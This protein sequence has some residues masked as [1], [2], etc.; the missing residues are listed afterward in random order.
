M[1]PVFSGLTFESK[2]LAGAVMILTFIW[3]CNELSPRQRLRSIPN[4]D[5]PVCKT[6]LYVSL[7]DF[8]DFTEP[9][10]ISS[11]NAGNR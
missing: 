6:Y 7:L 9:D 8:N 11:T 4:D 10:V 1:P 5:R 2:Q 3:A